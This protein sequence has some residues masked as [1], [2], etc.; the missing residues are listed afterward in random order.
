MSFQAAQPS[1]KFL[2]LL[3]T[4]I[5]ATPFLILPQMGLIKTLAGGLS[6]AT[7]LADITQ[8]SFAG[9]ALEALTPTATR[10]NGVGDYVIGFNSA[11]FQ[12]SGTVT[13][14][15]AV[16]G[17][18]VQDTVTAVD[19]LLFAEIFDTPFTFNLA[20]D[21]LALQYDIYVRNLLSW[22]GLCSIC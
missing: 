2:S 21:A 12:P 11:V 22:G 9:Y 3:D 4:A 10:K 5:R 16:I 19:H 17:Y 13:P 7:V 6:A 14:G 15:E 8:P 18:F 1:D 20:T